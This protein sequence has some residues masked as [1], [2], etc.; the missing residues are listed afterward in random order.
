MFLEKVEETSEPE[1]KVA[2][3][4]A[5]DE[6]KHVAEGQEVWEVATSMETAVATS[7]AT[8][9]TTSTVTTETTLAAEEALMPY[10]FYSNNCFVS[11]GF[12]E[13]AGENMLDREI[14]MMRRMMMEVSWNRPAAV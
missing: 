7:M 6:P 1:E 4:I 10:V 5:G 9:E 14:E 11:T 13:D 12:I 8:T 2:D 3:E